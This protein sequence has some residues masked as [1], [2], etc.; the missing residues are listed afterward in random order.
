[1]SVTAADYARVRSEV[2]GLFGWDADT[3]APA[4]TLRVDCAVALRLAL[5]EAQGRLI[6][7]ET[8]D[9][10]K[11]LVASEALSRLLP[12]AVLSAPPAERRSD[13]RAAL[14]ELIL[15]QRERAGVPPEGI[16]EH[17][18]EV[19]AL[20]A[21]NETLRRAAMAAGLVVP[22]AA[23]AA[24]PVADI[25]VVP[26]GELGDFRIGGPKPAPDDRAAPVTIEGKAGVPKG[27]PEPAPA[28][29]DGAV[30]LRYGYNSGTP[31]PWRDHVQP[32][33]SISPTPFGG[34]RKWWGPV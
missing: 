9:T 34:G 33:G 11:M 3:L 5:D 16:S 29:D 1:M 7:G 17:A 15:K 32:D 31:E 10:A 2:V 14:L 23:C 13:P 21:E 18:G 19:A 28:A 4:Q 6:R 22:P 27:P 20:R 8:V 24:P 12:A 25:D 30:D 26:P